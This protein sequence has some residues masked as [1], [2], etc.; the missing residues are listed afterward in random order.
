MAFTIASRSLVAQTSSQTSRAADEFGS[1]S[2]PA[3]ARS[4]WLSRP[5][6]SGESASN[7][8]KTSESRSASSA[9]PTVPSASFT[10]NARSMIRIVPAST[11]SFR[12]GTIS[13]L[14]WF[15]GNATIMY[16]TG[17]I[18]MRSP[19]PPRL[20]TDRQRRELSTISRTAGGFRRRAR[21]DPQ[22]RVHPV[23]RMRPGRR[24]REDAAA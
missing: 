6:V 17:P 20:S 19:L 15:P 11:S 9:V 4:S 8:L 18:D 12:A 21:A 13:P 14:N 22:E 2:S 1:S 5:I 3:A 10:T 24:V 23:R 16:S 7:A